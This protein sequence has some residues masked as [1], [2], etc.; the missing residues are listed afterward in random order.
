MA[1]DVSVTHIDSLSQFSSN[2]TKFAENLAQDTTVWMDVMSQKLAQLENTKINAHSILQ[3]I[4]Q[5]KMQMF[6][7][8]SNIANSNDRR[9]VSDALCKL[10][11]LERKEREALRCVANID[12]QVVVARNMVLV[13][14][15]FTK[16]FQNKINSQVEHG[17]RFI[18]N[19]Q[20][21]LQQYKDNA[22]LI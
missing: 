9:L 4:Q 5:E 22:S 3:K 16:S 12:Q 18:L 8:Y 10:K 13:M 21:Q 19:S 6:R 14:I 1:A 7:Y 17:K 11:E 15:N 2:L 20:I